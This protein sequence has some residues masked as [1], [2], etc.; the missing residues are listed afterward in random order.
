MKSKTN[1]VNKARARR[2]KSGALRE[3]FLIIAVFLVLTFL[4]TLPFSLHLSDNVLGIPVD[5]LLNA[6]IMAWDAHA[7]VNHPTALFDA[8]FNHPSRDT[9]AFSE[10]LFALGVL[11][12]PLRAASKN[13]IL[14]HNL[15]LLVCFALSGYTMYLLAKY[16]TANRA[17][18]LLAGFLFAFAPYHFSTIV[19]IHVT[20]Y[21][22]HPLVLFF[23]IRYFEEVRKRF[24]LG[25]GLTFLTQ[26][27]LSWY[28]LAFSMLY[29]GLYL[30]WRLITTRCRRHFLSLIS[31]VLTIIICMLFVIPFAVPYLKLRKNVLEAESNPAE[32]PVVEAGPSDYFRVVEENLLYGRTRILDIGYIGEGNALFMGFT[33]LPL[34]LL[35]LISLFA[36]K[37][38]CNRLLRSSPEEPRTHGGMYLG[39]EHGIT[40]PE[41]TLCGGERPDG[42]HTDGQ[43]ADES[44]N[45]R[46]RGPNADGC[47]PERKR[48]SSYVIFFL[49]LG[50]LSLVLSTGM[51]FSGRENILYKYLHKIPIFSLVRFP[52]RYHTLVVLSSS[53]LAAYGVAWLCRLLEVRG[54]RSIAAAIP[55]AL[56]A[57][58]AV[59]FVTPGM[60]FKP[61]PVGDQVPRVYRDLAR[62]EKG[63]LLEAPMPKVKDL[64]DFADPLVIEYGNLTSA[65]RMAAREQLALYYST[66]NWQKLVN[67]MSGYYPLFYRRVLVEM[68]A[69]PN[70]RSLLFLRSMGVKYLL[71]HWDYFPGKSG[72]QIRPLLEALPGLEILRDYPP[73]LTL[74]QL[75][76]SETLPASGL[77]LRAL[78]PQQVHPGDDFNACLAISNPSTLPFLNPEEYRFTLQMVWKD[79]AGLTVLSE[80]TY[81]YLPFYIHPGDESY[82]AF[83]CRAPSQEGNYELTIRAQNGPFSGESWKTTISVSTT[84]SASSGEGISG[85]LQPDLEALISKPFA[86]REKN[87]REYQG[88]FLRLNPDELFSLPLIAQNTGSTSWAKGTHDEKGKVVVAALWEPVGAPE[89][90]TVQHSLLPCDIS[91]G[92]RVSF[93]ATLD[94]PSSPGEYQ[95]TVFLICHQ[96]SRIGNVITLRVEIEQGGPG[97]T[98]M[99]HSCAE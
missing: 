50:A 79:E 23:L 46:S 80:E 93:S 13:P 77:H 37:N 60:P 86:F 91:P 27:L 87:E 53:V 31:T 85:S 44:L 63:V 54:K 9:L 22:L 68:L 89:L 76:E 73:S 4:F 70:M 58:T 71:V 43:A 29:I 47:L 67:G 65:L 52:I 26:A 36:G 30:F 83:Q 39:R 24:L 17:A 19:H 95:L 21:F 61:V 41:A 42:C 10:H 18:A 88:F 78:L 20:L 2:G 25:F 82:A 81:Y 8:N 66:Y 35:A 56:L 64:Y 48:P 15:I 28:Q 16:L 57:L 62:M 6:Y 49:F 40:S 94:A 72:E 99:Y 84:T 38:G 14:A 90:N 69:F 1:F 3:H 32:K 33:V 75:D 59:E 98:L 11:S 12:I 96:V 74:Y 5:N 92:Q 55:F 7:L 51:T 45:P 97:S 34:L